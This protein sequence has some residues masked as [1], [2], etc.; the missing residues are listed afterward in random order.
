MDNVE[1]D[2]QHGNDADVVL[3]NGTGG[4]VGLED[5][6]ATGTNPFVGRFG[7]GNGDEI[8]GHESVDGVGVGGGVGDLDELLL[9]G[10]EGLEGGGFEERGIGL[11]AVYGWIGLCN[12]VIIIE[13]LARR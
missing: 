7:D 12:R 2:V 9:V 11:H 4:A 6:G 5:H 1:E 10:D 8:V 13:I 3:A